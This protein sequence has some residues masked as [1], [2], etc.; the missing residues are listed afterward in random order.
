VHCEFTAELHD[1]VV[2]LGIAVQF[3]QVSDMPGFSLRYLPAAQL[4]HA[5]ELADVQPPGATHPAI[6]GHVGHVSAGGDWS[7]YLPNAHDVHWESTAEEQV[8]GDVQ[9]VTSVQTGHADA[10]PMSVR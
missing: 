9:P 2:Q 7:R 4:M 3:S 10:P 1:C 6:A 5:E 8:N